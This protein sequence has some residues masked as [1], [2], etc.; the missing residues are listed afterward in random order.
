MIVEPLRRV[1]AKE[2]TCSNCGV[3]EDCWESFG[4]QGDQTSQSKGNQPWIFSGRTDAEAEVP[5]FWPPDVKK[6]LIGKKKNWCWERLKAGG[7]GGNREWAGWMASPTPWAWVWASS[8]SCWWTR[9]PSVL[10][11]MGSQG[12]RHDWATELAELNNPNEVP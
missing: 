3:R 10:Q 5:I 4:H 6:W 8:G 11:A 12:V 2:L 7:E 1:T 9:K